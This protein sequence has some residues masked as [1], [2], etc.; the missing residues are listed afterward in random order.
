MNPVGI[1]CLPMPPFQSQNWCSWTTWS[2]IQMGTILSKL[3]HCKSLIPFPTPRTKFQG[4]RFFLGILEAEQLISTPSY[5]RRHQQYVVPLAYKIGTTFSP[6]CSRP[7]PPRN[8]TNNLCLA[9]PYSPSLARTSKDLREET[10]VALQK[11]GIY[12]MHILFEKAALFQTFMIRMNMPHARLLPPLCFLA[13]PLIPSSTLAMVQNV[14]I[15]VEVMKSFQ[16]YGLRKVSKLQM[17]IKV[18]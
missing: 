14:E 4:R 9:L 13:Y 12:R 18:I 8:P 11:H 16:G 5:L 2:D 10:L 1:H 3:T 7:H 17:H 15:T 6:R